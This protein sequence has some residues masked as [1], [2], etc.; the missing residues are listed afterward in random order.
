MI[1]PE[2][3]VQAEEQAEVEVL[4]SEPVDLSSLAMLVSLLAVATGI[5]SLQDPIQSCKI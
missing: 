3:N 2:L 1:L 5:A 4:E